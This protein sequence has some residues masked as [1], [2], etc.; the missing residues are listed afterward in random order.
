MDFIKYKIA[1]LKKKL[2]Y[3]TKNFNNVSFDLN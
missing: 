3:V 1:E 2:G